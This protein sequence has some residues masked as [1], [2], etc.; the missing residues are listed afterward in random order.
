METTESAL[1]AAERAAAA[2][3]IEYPATPWWYPLLVAGFMTAMPGGP[4]LIR[5]GHT[6]L[7]FGVQALAV[8]ALFAFLTV[9]RKKWGA[10]P[11]MAAAP[12]EIKEA[13]R[14]YALTFA[15]GIFCCIGAW[16]AGGWQL[17]LPVIFVATFVLV[18]VY[19]RTVY[20]R[21]ARRVRERLA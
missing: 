8:G 9:Y 16:V 18:W 3:F 17:G 1:R 5:H 14:W 11:R 19:E 6:F 21:A 2:P 15:A 12:P 7:G 13:Y 10:W 4:V 20:P